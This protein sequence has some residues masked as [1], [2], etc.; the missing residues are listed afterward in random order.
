MTSTSV[1]VVEDD[2]VV[3]RAIQQQLQRIGYTIAGTATSGEEA[4]ELAT[5]R[6]PNIV[7]MD[8][9][10][11]GTLDG[12]EAADIIRERWRIP[13]VFLTAYAD[14]E[15][16]SRANHAEPF[17]F[18]PKPFEELQLRTSIEMALY[19]HSVEKRLF[20]SER[21]YA[22]TLAS[23]GDA[24][25]ATDA[26]GQ[27]TFMNPVAETL[28][29]WSM[30]DANGKA[31]TAVFKIVNEDSRQPVED[32]V[33]KVLRLGT[34]VGLANHTLLIAKDGT[35]IPIDDSG[36]PIVDDEGEITGAVLVFRDVVHR[37]HMD[38]ALRQAQADLALVARLTRLGELAA[39]I[40]HEVT[41]PLTAI[42]SNAETCL[43]FLA[44]AKEAAVRMAENSHRAGDVVKSIRGL[45]TQSSGKITLVDV[46]RVVHEVVELLRGDIRRHSAAIEVNLSPELSKVAGDRVRLQQ[47]VCNLLMNALEALEGVP[48]DNRKI[49]IGSA[50][51]G[52]DG[53]LIWVAD[54]G[55]GLGLLDTEKLFEAMFTTKRGGMG[56]GLSICRSIVEAHGGRIWASSAEGGNGAIF[57]FTVPRSENED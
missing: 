37:R 14:N 50:P 41:Q 29:R 13:V 46:N 19:K 23:I 35:E 36:A 47:V 22:T 3:S 56:L 30:G 44:Q 27:I 10:L 4:V 51:E 48:V 6:K 9:R 43:M 26:L 54:N 31:V 40:A 55:V 1:L 11:E 24:V 25:I 5:K 28:T 33:A 32:P 57:R 21:R 39:S 2:S 17:G 45:A 15:T 20:E 18:L 42:V 53:R 38:E 8:I 12:I 52:N 34:I 7:L 49:V 16:I